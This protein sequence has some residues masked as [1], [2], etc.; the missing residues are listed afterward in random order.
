MIS[1]FCYKYRDYRI[2][3]VWGLDCYTR[4]CIELILSYE[5]LNAEEIKAI[6]YFIQKILLPTINNQ[7]SDIAYNI[8]FSI[9]EILERYGMYFGFCKRLLC[10]VLMV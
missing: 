1:K 4:K 8:T 2:R 7:D 6:E 10:Y 5:N 3:N 9:F